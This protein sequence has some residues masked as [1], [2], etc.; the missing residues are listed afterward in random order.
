MKA[1]P[2]KSDSSAEMETKVEIPFALKEQSFLHRHHARA[3]RNPRQAHH[4]KKTR[5]NCSAP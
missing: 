3:A 2:Q 1:D 4:P 5:A